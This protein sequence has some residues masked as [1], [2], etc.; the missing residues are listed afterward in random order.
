MA[1]ASG[2]SGSSFTQ[3]PLLVL[4]GGEAAMVDVLNEWS[5]RVDASLGLMSGAFSDLRTEVV[6]PQAARTS[7]LTTTEVGLFLALVAKSYE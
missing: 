2:A 4:G 3:P 7:A 5:R 6:E 1:A